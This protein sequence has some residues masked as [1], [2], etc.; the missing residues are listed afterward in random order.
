MRK[1]YHSIREPV[2]SVL[3]NAND[4]PAWIR[5]KDFLFALLIVMAALF[6]FLL[7][8]FYNH[9]SADDYCYAHRT[10]DMGFW[11]VQAFHYYSWTGRYMA[12]ALLTLDPVDFQDLTLY[13]L[14]PVF[15][16]VSFG[17]SIYLFVSKLLPNVVT[18]DRL[19]LS[20]LIFFLYVVRLPSITEA[21]YWMSGS[22]TYQLASIL[23]LFLFSVIIHLHAQQRRSKR[24][25]YTLVA[26]VLCVVIVGLNETSMMLLCV[27][28]FLWLAIRFY[29]TRKIDKPLLVLLLVTILA[30][31]V[32]IAA[33]G[34]FIR[35]AE[36][37]KRFDVFISIYGPI[38]YSLT[39]ILHW[40]PFSVLLL[41]LFFS[42]LLKRIAQSIRSYYRL[43]VI[44]PR[45]VGLLALAVFFFIALGFLPSF[46]AQGST[47][48]AR[49][50]N[51]IYLL[52]IF[53]GL[54]VVLAVLIS[55]QM[56]HIAI[57]EIPRSYRIV[58][59][60][61]FLIMLVFWPNKIRTAYQDL[62]KGTAY[63][64]DL[65]MQARY[66]HLSKCTAENCIVPPLENKPHSI[67]SYD[68]ASAPTEQIYYYNQCLS[69]YFHKDNISTPPE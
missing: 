3:I 13:R 54:A 33:P 68:L 69:H 8:A 34:N 62:A 45:H 53:S 7:L 29:L 20:F 14:L 22:V 67:Y 1:L 59:G 50:V 6:P 57:P 24:F 15:L 21:F 52:Y 35:M 10:N 39:Y 31:V 9:P 25:L 18:R 56:Q 44:S 61:L 43:P 26:A 42:D 30:S 66:R 11:P 65:E 12:T 40:L 2:S 38:R 28:L 49:T 5:Y 17:A 63:Q 58:L 23:S 64:Y 4:A 27:A 55:M 47:P 16:F 36:K 48:P 60:V 32:V 19:T 46:V 41:L 37:P 51:M